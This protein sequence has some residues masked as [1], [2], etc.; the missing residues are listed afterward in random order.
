MSFILH[1]LLLSLI[2]NLILHI[3]HLHLKLILMIHA[4]FN[5]DFE[6]LKIIY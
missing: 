1:L 2:I 5:A 6:N 4:L 3:N